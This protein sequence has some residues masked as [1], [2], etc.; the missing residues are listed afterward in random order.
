MMDPLKDKLYGGAIVLVP[1]A[2]IGFSVF[3]Y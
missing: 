3:S 2:A 1:A